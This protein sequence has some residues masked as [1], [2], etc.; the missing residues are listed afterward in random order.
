MGLKVILGHLG[1][2][3]LVASVLGGCGGLVERRHDDGSATTRDDGA[4]PSGSQA[5]VPSQP[6]AGPSSSAPPAGSVGAPNVGTLTVRMRLS[7]GDRPQ[8]QQMRYLAWET[9][10]TEPLAQG[11]VPVLLI[12]DDDGYGLLQA[13]L[14]LPRLQGAVIRLS[15]DGCTGTLGPITVL[16][17]VSLTYEIRL[18]CS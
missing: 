8:F 7:D 3:M 11:Q 6:T 10:E 16:P 17:D 5:D 14:R 4:A 18:T 13:S 1:C 2:V 12:V 9:S 15:E